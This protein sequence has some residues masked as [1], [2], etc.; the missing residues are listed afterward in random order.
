[1][2]CEVRR[3]R[4]ARYLEMVAEVPLI[5]GG[6]CAAATLEELG[7]RLAEGEGLVEICKEW[8]VPYGRVMTWLM[9]DERRWEVY[10]KGLEVGAHKEVGEALRIA[11]AVEGETDS[12]VVSAA[13]LR[14]DTRFRRAKA[15]A[16][17]MYGEDV[18]GGNGFGAGGV[19][20][21]I[22]SVPLSAPVAPGRLV[23]AG[24][25]GE[26]GAEVVPINDAFS[27]LGTVSG[28]K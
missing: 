6:A 3:D 11:D 15:H 1:M 28:D 14:I 2:G 27:P 26:R 21:V 25:A 19:T 23:G 5:E 12:A 18:R 8:D 7:Q 10:R 20:I 24:A 4:T 16:K 17:E 22:G 13:K 9:D